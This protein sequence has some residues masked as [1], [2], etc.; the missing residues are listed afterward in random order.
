M[1]SWTVPRDAEM[2][3]T[4][5]DAAR[6]GTE[7]SF[8][9]LFERYHRPAFSLA[10]R[11]LGD[12]EDAAEVTQEAFLRVH[13]HLDRFRG[14]SNFYTWMRRI[15][16]N[17]AIDRRRRRTR[18]EHLFEEQP[19]RGER[20]FEETVADPALA[21]SPRRELLRGE[22]AAV[23]KDG[24]AQLDERHRRV[25]VLR[26]IDGLSYE[27]IA[28]VTEVPVGTV[29]SRLFHARRR[30]RA[31]MEAYVDQDLQVGH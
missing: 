29:M 12:R 8:D 26:E 27:E 14:D 22:L 4:I 15:V 30:M 19:E 9:R 10:L 23:M 13:K 3:A 11:I 2:D 25:L 28:A 18:A 31:A 6:A 5:L 17:L 20:S 21:H 7:G 16:T 1:T 24:F